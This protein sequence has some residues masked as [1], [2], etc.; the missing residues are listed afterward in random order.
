M[1]DVMRSFRSS[2]MTLLLVLAL[3]GAAS[4][5]TQLA[6]NPPP[7]TLGVAV[8]RVVYNLPL[9]GDLSHRTAAKRAVEELHLPPA[10]PS[11]SSRSGRAYNL[12]SPAALRPGTRATGSGPCIH[13]SVQSSA[14]APGGEVLRDQRLAVLYHSRVLARQ[15]WRQLYPP[16]PRTAPL[17]VVARR[18]YNYYKQRYVT[19]AS[20]T[21]Q[22]QDLLGPGPGRTKAW[23]EGH[24]YTFDVV[25]PNA[26]IGTYY[27][28]L[29]R[30]RDGATRS[31]DYRV[32]SRKGLRVDVW[33][34]L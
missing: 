21:I 9:P 11:E 24:N 12:P 2:I 28:V 18:Y 1:E 17:R 32:K 19:V 31:W 16:R 34:P 6:F 33:R 15:I 14:A 13:D 5:Q 3:G 23:N 27:K 26:K 25:R 10:R 20:V 7:S 29:V 4:A 22:E 30:W 8:N